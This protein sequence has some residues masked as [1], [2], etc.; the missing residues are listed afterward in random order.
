MQTLNGHGEQ[1]LG[2]RG[3]EALLLRCLQ[4]GSSEVRGGAQ[5]GQGGAG[6]QGRQA[7]DSG[8]V[9]EQGKTPD[10][11][12]RS[13]AHVRRREEAS[14]GRGGGRAGGMDARA[15]AGGAEGHYEDAD[16][17]GGEEGQGAGNRVQR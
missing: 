1:N 16:G 10:V 8:V 7:E 14:D 13:A 6:L 15:S 3:Q 17:G 12:H 2:R 4:A 9:P 5:Q 11:S